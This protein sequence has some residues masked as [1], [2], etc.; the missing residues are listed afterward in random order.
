MTPLHPLLAADA[1]VRRDAI[2][3]LGEADRRDPAVAYALRRVLA[4]DE[5]V[6]VRAAA[7]YALALCAHAEDAWLVGALED[8]SPTVRDALIRGLAR[9][10]APGVVDALAMRAATDIVWWV[11][12]SAIYAIGVIAG[13]AAIAPCRAALSDPFWRVRHAAVQVLAAH[14]ARMPERR[15]EI[16]ADVDG[17][18]ADYLRALWGPAL[19]GEINSPPIASRLP[20]ALRDRDPAVVT[21]RLAVM[22]DPPALALVE[23][24]CDPHVPL[25]TLA[26]E[27]VVEAGD[28]DAFAAALHWLDEPR[29]PHVAKT[30]IDMLDG[31][32]DAAREL[33]VRVLAAPARRGALRWALGWVIATRDA[34]LRALAW[35]R[36]VEAQ[37]EH[38]ALALAPTDALFAISTPGAAEE[39]LGRSRADR[40]RLATA[41][42]SEALEVYGVLA[43]ASVDLWDRVERAARGEHSPA[44]AIAIGCLARAHR[45]DGA[46]RT[47]AL[48]D[49]DPEVRETVATEMTADE[50]DPWV[51]RAI[52]RR[53]DVHAAVVLAADPD[54]WISARGISLLSPDQLAICLEHAA[55]AEP[56]VRTAVIEQLI[57]VDDAAL[58]A[59]IP[60]LSP[61]A[62]ASAEAWI[63]AGDPDALVA[64]IETV[65]ESPSSAATPAQVPRRTFGRAGF[66]ISPLVVSGA[67]ELAPGS[68]HVAAEAGVDMF[69]WEPTYT[70]M[71][72]FLRAPRRRDTTRVVTGT[73]H[74]DRASIVLDV[75]RAL[76][77][78]RRDALDVFLLFWSRSAARLDA[79]AFETLAEL[80]RA[81][82]IRAAGFSTHDRS[83]AIAALD[84]APWDVVMTRHSAAHP[85]MEPELLPRAREAGAAVLSFS[86]LC[87]GRM[88]S[89][90]GA[91][92]PAECY[93]YSLS[94]PGVTACISAPRRH[95]ELV[96]NLEVVVEPALAA[97]RF[98]PVREHGAKVRIEN[99]RFNQ[100]IRQ[101]TR[102]AAAAAMAMLEAELAP[103]DRDEACATPSALGRSLS[104]RGRGRASL[105][106]AM[107]RR[108]RL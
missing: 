37:L 83:L 27:R 96:E 9:R 59:V 105:P 63:S 44:R 8:G 88:V 85:G 11:R 24:L 55:S 13:A 28:L 14:G 93:R 69:F 43:A 91:P 98:A 62:R 100:L 60:T 86:A 47:S 39:V 101:P 19:V 58:R 72:R 10:R 31:L 6:P 90:E 49:P 92:T 77:K 94:Q 87:Y 48:L 61:A 106:S 89:G 23:L 74:A 12:R 54:P 35:Q 2:T 16:L 1:S 97:E 36:A 104:S 79:E 41:E 67:F 80:K 107:L 26:V 53:A 45:L 66:A 108:G 40:L 82:K 33:V 56:I 73:Y 22:D 15:G 21:A 81:G 65:I 103:E 29:I 4:T 52:A 64:P 30:V 71:T 18:S 3:A 5:D 99:Q 46:L 76:K 68:L 78:L 102:D 38:E 20:E 75:D 84:A 50:R 17:G 42:L 25:R 57:S 95:R 7:A 32:G 70:A 34:E 51:R